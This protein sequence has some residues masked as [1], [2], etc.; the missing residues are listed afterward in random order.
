MSDQAMP[1]PSFEMPP[2]VEVVLGVQ[3]EAIKG[4]GTPQIGLLWQQ[5]RDRF[6]LTEDQ[7]PLEPQVERFGAARPPFPGFAFHFKL[8]T[9]RCW[10][11]NPQGTELIQVQTDRFL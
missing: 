1:L 8:P 4:F 5:F 6:P 2:V 9:P 10:F 11:L 3:F 7:A